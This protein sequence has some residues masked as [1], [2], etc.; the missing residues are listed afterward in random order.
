MIGWLSES[1]AVTGC[2]SLSVESR[3]E[4]AH[5]P[6]FYTSSLEVCT[7]FRM[8]CDSENFLGLKHMSITI[9]RTWSQGLFPLTRSSPLAPSS[10]SD[11]TPDISPFFILSDLAPLRNFHLASTD[12]VPYDRSHLVHHT[13]PVR[14]VAWML[15]VESPGDFRR[16]D[17]RGGCRA[18]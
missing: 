6:F 1:K 18:R 13:S 3:W 7:L 16:A 10:Y 12:L 15:C 8:S 5:H 14:V 2:W 17:G 4:E 9:P 11:R